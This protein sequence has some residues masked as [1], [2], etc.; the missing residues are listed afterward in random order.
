MHKMKVVD[1]EQGSPGWHRWRA[2]GMTASNSAVVQGVS[3]HKSA[4]ELWRELVGLVEPE[5]LSKIQQV[6]KGHLMEP[7]AAEWFEQQYGSVTGPCCG[8]S[9]ATPFMRASFDAFH[10]EYPLEIKNLSDTNHLDVLGLQTNSEHYELYYWQVQH[11][12]YVSGADRGYLLFWN[13]VHTPICFVIE[14][15]NE[16]IAKIIKDNEAFFYHHVGRGIAPKYDTSRDTC[17]LHRSVGHYQK[18]SESA[19]DVGILLTMKSKLT[20]EIGKI[21]DQLKQHKQLL[22]PDMADHYA[23]EGAGIRLCRSSRSGSINWEAA[24][25][26]LIPETEQYRLEEFRSQSSESV[27]LSI[28]AKDIDDTSVYRPE[29]DAKPEVSSVVSIISSA[30]QVLTP[31]SLAFDW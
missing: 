1:L 7:L 20:T 12:M 23:M 3:P 5:D 25:R 26:A 13:P 11:Q 17:F 14:R 8:E 29:K 30:N 2:E 24:A 31:G 10:G 18:W 21:D 4:L 15:S 27:R 6:R 19:S 16:C 9:L 22:I 28:S